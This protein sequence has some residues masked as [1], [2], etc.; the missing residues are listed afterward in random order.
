MPTKRLQALHIQLVHI[1]LFALM[2]PSFGVL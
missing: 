2:L 1:E